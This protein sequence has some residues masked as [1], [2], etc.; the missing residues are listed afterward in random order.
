MVINCTSLSWSRIF[1]Q[2]GR[3]LESVVFPLELLQQ[4][5]PSDF[6]NQQ[7]F[8][9][10]Q[11]KSL[12]ILEA[13][14][15][16]YPHVPLDKSDT[17]AQ[18][19]KQIIRGASEKPL[20]TGKNSEFMQL[21]R[22]VVMTLACRSFDDQAS[23]MCHWADGFPLNLHIYQMLLEA[24]F[25][26]DDETS[27][28]EEVDEVLE[29]IKKTWVILGMNQELHNLCFLWI[30]FHRYVET[31]EIEEELLFAASNL[32]IQV[33]NDAKTMKDLD[34]SKVLSSLLS[35]ILGWAEKQL[36]TYHDTFRSGSLELMQSVATLAVT[37]AKILVEDISQEY[38]K[39]RK[40]VNVARVRVET[41]L[42]SSIRTAFAQV[43]KS[44]S[45]FV[46]KRAYLCMSLSKLV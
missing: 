39:K 25:D 27:I 46:I 24:C 44:S 15:L 13:G 2:L 20:E 40:E 3:R 23:N 41:Y 33:E 14:L 16:L 17:A 19:L 7:E 43:I 35:A 9:A 37:S 22:T 32:L 34:Y 12:K 38:R 29:L 42:R 4:L 36:L 11:K 26:V 8:E 21:L 1:Y 30:L 28:I 31:G 10:F 6:P 45:L 5:K 18:R